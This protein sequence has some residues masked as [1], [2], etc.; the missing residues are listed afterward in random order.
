MIV[1][2]VHGVSLAED[3][4]GRANELLSEGE[5]RDDELIGKMDELPSRLDETGAARDEE[6]TTE[7]LEDPYAGG[8]EIEELPPKTPNQQNGQHISDTSKLP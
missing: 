2:F 6:S 8:P 7:L 3:E 5:I 1:V 4:A